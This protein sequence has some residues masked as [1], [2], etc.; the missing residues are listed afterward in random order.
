ML[1]QP[2]NQKPPC[3]KGQCIVCLKSRAYNFLAARECHHAINF[4]THLRIP[5]HGTSAS[6]GNS[7]NIEKP[8]F[9]FSMSKEH[10]VRYGTTLMT[11]RG[12]VLILYAIYEVR[13]EGWTE[14]LLSSNAWRGQWHHLHIHMNMICIWASET[15]KLSCFW[16]MKECVVNQLLNFFEEN[17]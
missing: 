13:Q 15:G 10:N 7:G 9:L 1:S 8:K 6:F 12:T 5:T 11:K 4:S 17:K 14:L 16:I 3:P 2:T